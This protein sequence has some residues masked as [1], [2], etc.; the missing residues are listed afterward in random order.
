VTVGLQ[1]SN[2]CE[3]HLNICAILSQ[4]NKH[5]MALHHAM[6]ALVLI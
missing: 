6:K 2:P 1:I 5:E 4:L 3:I